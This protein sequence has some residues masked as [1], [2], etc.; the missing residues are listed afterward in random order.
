[1]TP[2][3]P[4]LD[5]KGPNSYITYKWSQK[6]QNNNL[7]KLWGKYLQFSQI[8]KYRFHKFWNFNLSSDV[9]IAI[10]RSR[11]TQICISAAKGD[12]RIIVIPKL[13]QTDISNTICSRKIKTRSIWTFRG[14]VFAKAIFLKILKI[15]VL[16]DLY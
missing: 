16:H 9:I 2:L 4:N 15:L 11:K 3:I 10:I 5:K 6:D 12:K 13:N 7:L 1:M 8:L 14:N